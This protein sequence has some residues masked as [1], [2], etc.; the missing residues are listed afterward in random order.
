M[1]AMFIEEANVLLADVIEMTQAEAEEVARRVDVGGRPEV[2]GSSPAP[3]NSARLAEE[4][5]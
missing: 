1:R 5:T 2:A 3:A 4:T